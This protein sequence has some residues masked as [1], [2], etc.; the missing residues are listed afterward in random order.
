M[1]DEDGGGGGGGGGGSRIQS[2]P[3]QDDVKEKHQ[4][5]QDQSETENSD[6][7]ALKKP[8]KILPCPR[9]NS[10]ETKF[11]YFNNYNVNQPRHFCKNCQRYWTAGGT[12]RNIPVG[13]GRRM[14][15]NVG[16]TQLG[17]HNVPPE[18]LQTLQANPNPSNPTLCE[19]MVF[20]LNIADKYCGNHRRELQIHSGGRR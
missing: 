14:N 16:L 12:M 13:A 4:T 15:K 9:C 3:K 6:E 18:A 2:G 19:S 1:E 17:H 5:E 11:C 8:D 10:V 7:K 20:V